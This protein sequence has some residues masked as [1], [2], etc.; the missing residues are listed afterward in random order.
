M[1][2]VF[3]N[4][5]LHRVNPGC[6]DFIS[7]YQLPQPHIDRAQKATQCFRTLVGIWPGL[8]EERCSSG[9]EMLGARVV[10]LRE[11]VV[12]KES[13]K[14]ANDELQLFR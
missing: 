4:K 12:E 6:L 2:T 14:P 9:S 3:V 1:L 11:D 7:P 8:V 5:F 10:L 13:I